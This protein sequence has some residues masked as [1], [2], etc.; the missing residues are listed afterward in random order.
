MPL[1]KELGAEPGAGVP[2]GVG[3]EGFEFAATLEAFAWAAA[4][5]AS[6]ASRAARSCASAH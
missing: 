5:S 2:A 3:V 4:S 1:L 6:N